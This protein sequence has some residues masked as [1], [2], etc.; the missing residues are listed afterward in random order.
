MADYR[1]GQVDSPTIPLADAVAASSA[2]PPVLSPARLS[3]PN[4]AMKQTKGADLYRK[5]YTTK[6]V[7]TDGG[8]YDNLGLE[9]VWKRYKTVIVSD[10][11]GQMPAEEDPKSDWAQH[12][13]RV[14]ALIDNQVRAMRKKLIVGSLVRGERKGVYW[15]MRGDIAKYSAP[16]ALLCPHDRTLTLAE[17]PTRLAKL[18]DLQQERI[19]N[20]GY[21]LCDAGMRAWVEK[22]LPAPKDFPYPKAK[23]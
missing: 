16:N 18:D 15:R 21:A 1:V 2:F 7:L 17:T 13:L 20:W 3:L 14:N 12:G 23:V 22:G 4:G 19:I 5:P 8:V 9:T 11:G 6:I 10:G